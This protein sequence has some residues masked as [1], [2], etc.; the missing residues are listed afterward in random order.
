MD[1]DDD[2]GLMVPVGSVLYVLESTFLCKAIFTLQFQKHW[3]CDAIFMAY[4]ATKLSEDR[5]FHHV[6]LFTSNTGQSF[7]PGNALFK[8][9]KSGNRRNCTMYGCV[10]YYSDAA[11]MQV[12][13]KI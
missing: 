2:T 8:D 6:Y 9:I 1:N 11:S 10:A 12:S 5:S 7:V 13:N 4:S 3:S